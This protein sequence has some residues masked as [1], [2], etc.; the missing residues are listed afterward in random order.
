MDF[1]D[2]EMA[3]DFVLE[4]A[5]MFVIQGELAEES[6]GMECSASQET[7]FYHDFGF[8]NKTISHDGRL[9]ACDSSAGNFQ[10][11]RNFEF[12]LATDI[13]SFVDQ[14]KLV[15]VN[16]ECQLIEIKQLNNKIKIVKLADRI[17][18]KCNLAWKR[19]ME[20]KLDQLRYQAAC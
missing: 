2:P 11:Q 17:A 12:H 15:F 18:S 7:E 4:I 16:Q 14:V 5:D 3:R 20:S 13:D 10:C 6:Y 8:R 19:S 1:C 9:G